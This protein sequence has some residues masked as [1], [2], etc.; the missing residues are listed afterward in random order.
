M[1]VSDWRFTK[2]PL[3]PVR[4]FTKKS[5]KKRKTIAKLLMGEWIKPVDSVDGEYLVKYRGGKGYVESNDFSL[6]RMLEIYF[7]DVGQGDCILVQTPDDR[8]ILIDGGRDDKAHSFLKW[9]YNLKNP[10]NHVVFD[11]IIMTHADED[12]AQ[13]LVPILNDP[14]ITV[15]SF[16]HNGIARFKS[17][18][19]GTIKNKLLVDV[20]DDITT[21]K[22]TSTVSP[23]YKNLI[24]SLENARTKNSDL[25]IKHLD[26]FSEKLDEFDQDDLTIKVL[27]PINVGTKT[28]P[29]YRYI[30]DSGVTLNGNSVSLKLEYG[31]AKILLCGDMN[32]PFETKFLE[33]HDNNKLRSHVFKANHHGSQD[34]GTPFLQAITPWISVISSGD[35]PDYGHPRA[36]LLGCLGKY[37]PKNIE[38]PLIFSTEIAATFKEITDTELAHMSTKSKMLYEKTIQGVIHVRTDGDSLVAGRVFGSSN[39]ANKENPNGYDWD[40][41]QLKL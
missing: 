3:T 2:N 37:A 34:F 6:K 7:I 12:H 14:Q 25:V 11:A 22:T 35:A 33:F 41:A 31:K 4:N 17:R 29:K 5:G 32:E 26:N 36:V 10:Q 39:L 40:Y 18:K 9:K 19:I 16:Y 21:L 38:R 1:P 15:N 8:R 28:S 27:G 24:K 30:K 23:D 13:G 20:Y